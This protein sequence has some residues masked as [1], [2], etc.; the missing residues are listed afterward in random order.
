MER[1]RR[2]PEGA[3][4]ASA[5]TREGSTCRQNPRFFLQ[6]HLQNHSSA[7]LCSSGIPRAPAAGRHWRGVPGQDLNEHCPVLTSRGRAFPQLRFLEC[8]R[9]LHLAE[10]RN[11][12]NNTMK[13]ALS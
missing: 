10:R 11:A 13:Q 4:G 3:S 7:Q 8:R 6:A 9:L 1:G 5:G 2:G 12:E